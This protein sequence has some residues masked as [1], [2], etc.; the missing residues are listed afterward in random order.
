MT[1]DVL[2]AALR[3]AIQSPDELRALGLRGTELVD[4]LGASRVVET[5]LGG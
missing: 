5:M 2:D 4:G 1:R 3:M